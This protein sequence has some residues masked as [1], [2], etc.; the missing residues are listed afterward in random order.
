MIENE[1]KC[2]KMPQNATKRQ[3]CHKTTKTAKKE[4]NIGKKWQN[5]TKWRKTAKMGKIRPKSTKNTKNTKNAQKR[6]KTAQKGPFL[7]LF[8]RKNMIKTLSCT[9]TYRHG[10]TGWKNCEIMGICHK[11]QQ[12]ERKRPKC[13]KNATK[14]QKSGKMQ[15]NEKRQE[16]EKNWWKK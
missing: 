1:A 4:Q 3:K 15:Q 5:A 2:H 11:M 6:P 10:K 12:N 14:R 16:N 9:S 13:N 7:G 8:E